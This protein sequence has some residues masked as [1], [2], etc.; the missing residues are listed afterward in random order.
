[1]VVQTYAQ[2]SQDVAS[3]KVVLAW[4][5]PAQRLV[6]WTL[7]S[8]AIYKKVVSEFVIEVIQAGT[9]LSE[10]QTL[11]AVNAPG[12]WFFDPYAKTLYLWCLG[13]VNPESVFVR[14]TYRL[15][16]ANAPYILPWNLEEGGFEVEY[17]SLISATSDFSYEID[18]E[19]IGVA[20]EGQGDIQL[21]N[22]H[23]YFDDKF[24]KYYWENKNV[25]VF[26]WSP[27]IPVSDKRKIYRGLISGKQFA[28]EAVSFGM[29]DFIS[30]LQDTL[31]MGVFDGTEGEVRQGDI[32]NTKRR[33]YGHVA[34]L[35]LT[36]ID[37]TLNGYTLTGTL[38]G[39]AGATVVTGVGTAF[40]DEVSPEDQLVYGEYTY[41]VKSVDSNTQITTTSPIE[42]N[43]N[44]VQVLLKP[45]IPWRKKNREW[46]IAEHAIKKVFCQITDIVQKNRF[47]V[48]TIENFEAGDEVII[49]GQKNRIRRLSGNLIVFEQSLSP[50]PAVGDQIYKYPIQALNQGTV[51]YVNTRDYDIVNIP[52]LAKVVFDDLAEFNVTNSFPYLGSATFTNG[53]RTVTGTGNFLTDFFPRDWIRPAN[54]QWYEI[55]SIE[56]E[57]QMTL[58]V[59][60]AEATVSSTG[61]KK[62]VTYLADDSV[63][64]VN[65]LGKTEDGTDEGVWIKTGSQAIRDILSDVG[66][67]DAINEASFARAA[68]EAPYVMSLKLP[69]DYGSKERPSAKD[70]IDLINVS[71]FGALH[72]NSDFEI[73]HNVITSK[74]PTNL[75]PLLEDDI[76]SW[77]VS[78]RIDHIAKEVVCLFAHQDADRFTQEQSSS[79][80]S[81]VN[82]VAKFLT[83]GKQSLT[84]NVYLYN[85]SEAST[86]NY[87]YSLYHESAS[88]II[89]IQTKLNLTQ[90]QITDKL[91]LRFD[92]LFYRLGSESSR[93]KICG[94]ISVKKNGIGTVLVLEDLSNAW[95]KIA[96]YAADASDIFSIADDDQKV[97]NGYYNNSNGIITGFDF[98]YRTNLYG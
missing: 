77:S 1:M 6:V 95:N 94:V 12:K 41:R 50:L 43:F 71:I 27:T 44:Q 86:I 7:H 73:E 63:V 92:R 33:I 48:T 25:S 68:Q 84:I 98:T 26:S 45:K 74:K 78:S 42:I 64:T 90:K 55:L 15:F 19:Q 80:A 88:H 23:G 17:Q 93:L 59:A 36:P 62:N 51:D 2:Y 31:A 65:C 24:D 79:Y 72:F 46:F 82:D 13:G 37:C 81:H 30:K 53:S 39:S 70:V 28:P 10:Q 9:F 69:L 5:E 58:R 76:V 29:K 34:G 14:A 87:R 89:T 66:I 38:S 11:S 4:F 35:Q 91:Y 56:S 67:D 32:G 20:L 57:T 85:R 8:G 3:E 60:F 40:L 16:F 61:E 47:L 22:S 18:Y 52:G 96:N 97:R 21:I 54:G 49:N 75:L 83:D